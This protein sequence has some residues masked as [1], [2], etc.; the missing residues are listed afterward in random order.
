MALLQLTLNMVYMGQR[1]IE[2]V[3]KP[4]ST[5]GSTLAHISTSGLRWP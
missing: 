2:P 5:L 1:E 4:V 3:R